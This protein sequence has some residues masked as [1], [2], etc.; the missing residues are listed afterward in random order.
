MRNYL[1][2]RLKEPSTY[3]GIVMCFTAFGILI[4]PEQLEAVTFIGL[5]LVGLL[6]QPL[7]IKETLNAPR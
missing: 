3:R 7:L 6:G 1:I 4:S 5:F 2:A